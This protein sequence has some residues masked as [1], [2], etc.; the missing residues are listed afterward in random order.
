[1]ALPLNLTIP[2][3]NM[4]LKLTETQKTLVERY[5]RLLEQFGLSPVATR[6]NALLTIVDDSSLTFDEIRSILQISKSA[7]STAL[8]TLILVGLINFR[9]VLGDRKRYF[10]TEIGSWKTKVGKDFEV[11][12]ELGDV[13]DDIAK[14]KSDKDLSQKNDVTEYSNFLTNLANSTIRSLQILNSEK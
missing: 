1:M 10:Y 5:G 12:L 13:L 11:L 4:A 8:N 9:T 14:I 6:I 7:T 3:R 2:K